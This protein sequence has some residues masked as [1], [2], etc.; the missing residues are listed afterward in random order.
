MCFPNKRTSGR[1]C[2]LSFANAQRA[3]RKVN[4]PDASIHDFEECVHQPMAATKITF[5]DSCPSLGWF[6]RANHSL[7]TPDL[8][9]S[10]NNHET[11]NGQVTFPSIFS[12]TVGS[13]WSGPALGMFCHEP[14]TWHEKIG[15]RFQVETGHRRLRFGS[16]IGRF[17]QC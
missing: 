14:N 4:C 15:S 2:I 9:V 12:H 5:R 1:T 6:F 13:W 8:L 11:P 10:H 17:R 3:S 7:F 16:S